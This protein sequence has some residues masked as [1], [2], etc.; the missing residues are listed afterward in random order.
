[1]DGLSCW[2]IPIMAITSS[3]ILGLGPL[4]TLASRSTLAHS[5]LEHLRTQH[6]HD[7]TLV[8]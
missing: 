2:L 3:E 7:L 5:M 1:M 4:V 6:G 8:L